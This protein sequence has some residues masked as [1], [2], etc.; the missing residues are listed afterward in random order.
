MLM[1]NKKKYFA[2]N[3]MT[4]EIHINYVHETIYK[5]MSL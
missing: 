1:K 2:A 5:H 3:K 4:T